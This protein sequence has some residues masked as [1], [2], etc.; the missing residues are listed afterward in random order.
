MIL[1][2]HATL[3]RFE[4]KQAVLVLET[5]DEIHILKEDLGKVS[6]GQV[7]TLQILPEKEATL[8]K[9][10]LARALLNQIL[11]D[12]QPAEKKSEKS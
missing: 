2:K 9:E 4:G 10:E 8:E 12:D 3:D 7:Y 11:I 5:G 1:R 6:E